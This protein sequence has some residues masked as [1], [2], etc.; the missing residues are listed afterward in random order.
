MTA[1]PSVEG[2]VHGTVRVP[3]SKSETNRALVLAALSDGPSHVTG[4]LHSR[5][6]AL[7][8]DALR[9]LGAGVDV[10]DAGTV[11][12][13]PAPVRGGGEVDCGLAGTVMRFVP[14]M[15]LLAD[16]PVAFHGDEHASARPMRGLL[17]ALRELGARVDGDALPFRVAPE[18]PRGG[19]VVVDASGSSQFVSGLLLVGARLGGGL[20]IRLLDEALPSRPHVAMTVAM[21]RQHG[22]RVETP[23]ERTWEVSPGPI[24]AVDTAVEPDLTNAAVFLAAAGVAGG[25]VS[26]PGWPA[27]TTQPGARFLDVARAMG[28]TVE[29]ASG[30][31]VLRG[32]SALHSPGTLDLHDAAELTPVVAALA[33]L[34][35]GTTTITG[36]AHVRGHETD[37]IAAI[38]T[39]LRRCGIAAD[40]LGD[41]L[42]ITGGTPRPVTLRSYADHRMVHLAALIA[43]VTPDTAVDDLACV[44]KTMPE[45]P[46]L[47]A[48]IL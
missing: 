22:V 13:R 1:L 24:R 5:D 43:L 10:D 6:S 3:G 36:I 33:A 17:D 19:E 30:T 28:C 7:M 9:A 48:G 21:L 25:T 26:V 37:R 8:I 39:E 18:A 31:A 29:V 41:G 20:R 32:T 2:P 14:P 23:D 4:A 27:V 12:V 47:W 40:E 11:L 35:E 34:A 16:G 45:F 42:R 46:T 15:V 44:S 38:V